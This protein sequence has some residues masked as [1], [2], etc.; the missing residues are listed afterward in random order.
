M[1]KEGIYSAVFG[2]TAS[3]AKGIF[4]LKEGRMVGLNFDGARHQGT[5]QYDPVRKSVTFDLITAMMPKTT[6]VTGD[7]VPEQGYKLRTRGEAPLPDPLSRF[8][9]DVL[10]KAVDVALTF[11]SPLP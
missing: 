3:I 10:G 6:L 4:V 1:I 9:L 5:Y 2:G 7:E 11:E 8:S